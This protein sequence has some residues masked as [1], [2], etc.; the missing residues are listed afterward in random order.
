[1]PRVIPKVEEAKTVLRSPYTQT[2]KPERR[3]MAT[4]MTHY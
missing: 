2:I 1:M 4:S 3:A